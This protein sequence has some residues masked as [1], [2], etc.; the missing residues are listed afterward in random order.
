M[1]GVQT[2]P[3]FMEASWLKSSCGRGLMGEMPVAVC[4]SF[5][6]RDVPDGSRQPVMVQPE[7]GGWGGFIVSYSDK[8]PQLS[9]LLGCK[10]LNESVAVLPVQYSRPLMGWLVFRG[11]A[12]RWAWQVKAMF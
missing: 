9:R 11:H 10:S 6:S 2:A 7:G 4:L 12:M 1:R 8:G 3:G 5:C